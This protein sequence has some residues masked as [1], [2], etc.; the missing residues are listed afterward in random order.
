MTI[1]HPWDRVSTEIPC[2]AQYF[3]T[4]LTN[5]RWLLCISDPAAWLQREARTVAF[6]WKKRSCRNRNRQRSGCPG[7]DPDCMQAAVVRRRRA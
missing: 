4:A 6:E 3:C 7:G 1:S 2:S 5:I